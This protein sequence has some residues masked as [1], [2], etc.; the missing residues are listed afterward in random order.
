MQTCDIWSYKQ[1]SDRNLVISQLSQSSPVA[2]LNSNFSVVSTCWMT[3]QWWSLSLFLGLL[4][5]CS[6]SLIVW[7]KTMMPVVR[8]VRNLWKKSEKSL[9]CNRH[10]WLNC[11][12]SVFSPIRWIFISFCC[13]SRPLF[14]RTRRTWRIKFNTMYYVTLIMCLILLWVIMFIVLG[15]LYVLDQIRELRRDIYLDIITRAE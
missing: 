2:S 3:F 6:L 1:P 13:L 8:T 11:Y 12:C 10:V 7:T 14:I 5:V 9:K 15:L 4:F